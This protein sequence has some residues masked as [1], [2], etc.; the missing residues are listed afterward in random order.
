MKAFIFLFIAFYFFFI[1]PFVL[2][3]STYVL[4]YPSSMPGSKFYLLKEV[5]DAFLQY[6][7]F[8]NF[9]QFTYNL[10]QSDTYLV[11]AKTLFEYDQYLLAADALQKSDEYFSKAPQFLQRA[12][13]EGKD[14]SEQKAL[15]Q[16]AAKKH[17]EV[18]EKLK[19]EVPEEF[20]WQPEK[21]EATSLPLHDALKKAI[22]IR[23]KF[24]I[25]TDR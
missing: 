24:V 17:I 4:P 22:R 20:V 10:K 8:G 18:L 11:E 25:P 9:G 13:E 16:S 6:W 15:L 5:K 14:I 19:T 7:Y 1:T 21:R 2:A 23:S 3:T 12:K